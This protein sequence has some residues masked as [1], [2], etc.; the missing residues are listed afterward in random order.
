MEEHLM[1]PPNG[2]RISR[3][4]RG[5]RKHQNRHDLAREALGLHARVGPARRLSA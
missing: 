3:R 5:I 4:K 1:K 2:L